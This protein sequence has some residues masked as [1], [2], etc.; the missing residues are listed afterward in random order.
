MLVCLCGGTGGGVSK[1]GASVKPVGESHGLSGEARDAKA[2]ELV[3]ARALG[4]EVK[5]TA[6][7]DSTS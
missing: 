3:R 4:S 1:T 7:K 6:T 2:V 5:G